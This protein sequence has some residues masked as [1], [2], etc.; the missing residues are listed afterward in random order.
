MSVE[1]IRAHY[2]TLKPYSSARDEWSGTAKVFLDANE[3]PSS[4]SPVRGVNRYPDPYCNSLKALVSE[5]KGVEKES[6]FVGNGSDEPIDLLIRL[7]C[8][9]RESSILVCPPTYGMYEVSAHINE[10]AVQEVPLTKN[11]ELDMD[12]LIEASKSASLIFLCSPNNPT[13]KCLARS[14]VKELLS[15]TTCPVVL[16]EAYIDF[17]PEKTLLNELHRWKNLIVLQTLSKAWGLAG[18]RIGFA[19][20][21]AGVVEVMNKIKAPYN[22]NTLSQSMAI[23]ALK[24][25]AFLSANARALNRER[26]RL[27]NELSQF[28]TCED[29]FDSDANFFL[30]KTAEP[31]KLMGH[32]ARR[33]III[34]DRSGMKGL[35][36]C[37]RISV[38]NVEENN[39]LI[40]EYREYEKNIVSGS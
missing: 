5:S 18:I 33:G 40:R 22:I 24:D 35:A 36:G 21:S 26:E 30:L 4:P 7:F 17:C 37:V 15:R 16:D 6:I 19:F 28:S 29:I 11:F 8:S 14:D 9:P 31:E 3:S 34:R 10:V 20:A 2:K 1:K 38:G 13:G 32:L 39:L 27:K 25:R 12:P 23:S